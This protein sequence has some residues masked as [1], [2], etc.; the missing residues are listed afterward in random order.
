[1]PPRITTN[2]RPTDDWHGTIDCM[3]SNVG[4]Q[5]HAGAVDEKRCSAK[6]CHKCSR[7]QI[8]LRSAD[9]TVTTLAADSTKST[10]CLNM[11]NQVPI[12]LMTC[13][14]VLVHVRKRLTDGLV[15]YNIH[16]G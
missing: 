4:W 6:A 12:G 13:S 3:T 15:S 8:H 10:K 2:A 5:E 14:S 9:A 11:S 7:V 1:M 16:S